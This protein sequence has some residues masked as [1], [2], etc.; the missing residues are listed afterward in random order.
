MLRQHEASNYITQVSQ[1]TLV[2]TILNVTEKIGW[3]TPH[4]NGE[5]HFSHFLTA[6]TNEADINL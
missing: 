4:K 3:E 2:S 6:T 5:C 1:V